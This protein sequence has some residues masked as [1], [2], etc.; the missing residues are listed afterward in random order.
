M[1]ILWPR[2]P[3]KCTTSAIYQSAGSKKGCGST[4]IHMGVGPKNPTEKLTQLVDHFGH[5]SSRNYVSNFFDLNPPLI[6]QGIIK[7]LFNL[8]PQLPNYPAFGRA[9]CHALLLPCFLNVDPPSPPFVPYLRAVLS[10]FLGHSKI[11]LLS[12]VSNLFQKYS[13]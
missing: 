13:C 1:W 3:E 11:N 9:P 8:S 2:T 10:C 7:I 12:T 5:L 6:K 4:N